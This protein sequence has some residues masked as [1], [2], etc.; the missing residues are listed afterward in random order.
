MGP[1]SAVTTSFTLTELESNVVQL[2]IP[3]LPP[4]VL[5]ISKE[6]IGSF[7][8]SV[9]DVGGSLTLLFFSLLLLQALKINITLNNPITDRFIN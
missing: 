1:P 4:V 5:V 7:T 6:V 9:T 3:L 2:P 8:G